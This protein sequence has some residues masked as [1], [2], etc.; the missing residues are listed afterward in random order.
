VRQ[1]TVQRMNHRDNS[2]TASAPMLHH[3]HH[4]N[5]ENNSTPGVLAPGQQDTGLVDELLQ[6]N[7]R[8]QDEVSRLRAELELRVRQ[9]SS[10]VSIFR[11]I[12]FS[13]R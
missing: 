3:L 4:S 1:P 10:N 9:F 2:Y 11:Q 13:F 7:T 8:L 12:T 6:E 5:A